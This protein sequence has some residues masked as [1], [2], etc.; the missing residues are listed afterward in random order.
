MPVGLAPKTAPPVKSE[1]AAI[2]ATYSGLPTIFS[3]PDAAGV[4]GLS[5]SEGFKGNSL[6]FQFV[7]AKKSAL[8][9]PLPYVKSKGSSTSEMMPFLT[10]IS[11]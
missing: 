9:F 11:M 8:P 4:G 5:R 3:P 2:S 6:L 1:L 10:C 7:G